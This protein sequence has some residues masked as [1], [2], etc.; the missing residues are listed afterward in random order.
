MLVLASGQ[1]TVFRFKARSAGATVR[2]FDPLNDGAR[3]HSMTVQDGE[4]APADNVPAV[5][6][7]PSAVIDVD[8]QAV[9]LLAALGD[10]RE[11]AAGMGPWRRD[12]HRE[13]DGAALATAALA[14]AVC[15]GRRPV[16]CHLRQDTQAGS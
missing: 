6:V 2:V 8:V 16:L 14:S 4:G 1:P 13:Q 5:G 11:V 15:P 9:G 3:V 7:I 12:A 10:R